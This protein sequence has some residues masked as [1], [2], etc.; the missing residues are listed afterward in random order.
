MV[1]KLNHANLMVDLKNSLEKIHSIVPKGSSIAY[2]DYPVHFNIGDLLIYL[3]T[4]QFFE[5]SGYN[6]V[7]SCCDKAEDDSNFI[8]LPPDVIVMMHGGGNFGDLYSKHQKLREKIIQ[9]YPENRVVILPQS[10]HFSNNEELRKSAEIFKTHT[11]VHICCR[12]LFSYDEAFNFSNNVYML[13]DMAHCLWGSI[14]LEK[15]RENIVEIKVPKTLIQNRIDKENSKQE[16]GHLYNNY[17]TY[18]WYDDLPISSRI[19]SSVI[20]R[21]SKLPIL[22]K[23]NGFIEAQWRKQALKSVCNACASITKYD[24]FVTNRLHGHIF[25][26]LLSMEHEPLDN[27][28][29]K[30]SRYQ[31]AWTKNSPIIKGAK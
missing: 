2:F 30:I 15:I 20:S 18:D 16:F 21:I 22:K 10:I 4:V 17:C 5:E 31:A 12:D 26:M 9:D 23:I 11:D 3:G 7:Y 28:Y 25:S 6:I 14:L 29:G 19:Y 8:D 13:P 24:N 1:K 27:S